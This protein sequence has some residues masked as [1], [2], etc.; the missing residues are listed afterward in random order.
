ME[1]RL[2]CLID[3]DNT[4]LDNDAGKR[5][6]DRRLVALLGER[7]AA[8]FWELYE[9]V[10]GEEGMVNMPLTMARFDGDLAAAPGADREEMQTRCRQLADL[11]MS[12]PP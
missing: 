4:L 9:V 8:R 7:P 11:V 1:P 2:T 10:R 3:V 5:E 12:F 6:M